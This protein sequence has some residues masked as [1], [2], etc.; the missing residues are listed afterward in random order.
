MLWFGAAVLE[1]S[2]GEAVPWFAGVALV[3]AEWTLCYLSVA[4][5][6]YRPV[7]WVCMSLPAVPAAGI[8]T[9]LSIVRCRLA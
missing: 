2:L 9:W 5:T 1:R 7:G 8:A 3:L 6:V 4:G